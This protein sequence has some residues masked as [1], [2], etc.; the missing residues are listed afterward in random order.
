[1]SPDQTLSQA[2]RVRVTARASLE[3]GV[4]PQSGDLQGESDAIDVGP[5]ARA[6]V[7]I[8]KRIP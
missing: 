8:D 3:G 6:T 2:D 1:M 7:M 5:D 4:M